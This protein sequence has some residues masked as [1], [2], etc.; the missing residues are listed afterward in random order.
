MVGL[1]AVVV[2]A[3]GLV[4]DITRKRLSGDAE[5]TETKEIVTLKVLYG[6]EVVG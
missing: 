5:N 6:W 1:D 4:F 2:R 3:N